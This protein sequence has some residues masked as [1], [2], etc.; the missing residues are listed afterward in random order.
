MSF[1][2]SPAGKEGSDEIP[3]AGKADIGLLDAP[4]YRNT[5]EKPRMYSS[6]LSIWES[7]L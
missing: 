3:K 6:F 5:M 4:R 2:S 7:S 1:G